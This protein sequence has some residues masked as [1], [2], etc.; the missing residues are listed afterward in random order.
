MNIKSDFSF[1]L[2]IFG[3]KGVGKTTL[4]RRALNNEFQLDTGKTLGADIFL[5]T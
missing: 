5:K 3:D 1:K 2:C 4:I